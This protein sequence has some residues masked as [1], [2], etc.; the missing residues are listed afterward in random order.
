MIRLRIPSGDR[1]MKCSLVAALAFTLPLALFSQEFR[2]VISGA[3]TD[4]TGASVAGAKITVT[5]THTNV[6]TQVVSESTGQYTAPFL[7]PGDYDITAQMQGFKEF[8][9]KGVHV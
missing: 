9:R 6:K 5:E 8:I 7:L 2:G 4:A 3:V 1:A